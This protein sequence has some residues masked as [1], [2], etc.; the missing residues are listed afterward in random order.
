MIDEVSIKSINYNFLNMGKLFRAIWE[1]S[2]AVLDA[3][4]GSSFAEKIRPSN[5][6]FVQVQSIQI[7]L[8]I[9]NTLKIAQ[10]GKPFQITE[11]NPHNP[12]RLH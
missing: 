1:F 7:Y 11:S 10:K 6:A 3:Q 5:H 9:I 4:L 12:N 8:T 2:V